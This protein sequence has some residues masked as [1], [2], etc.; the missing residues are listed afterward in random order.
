MTLLEC[1]CGVGN[2]VFPVSKLNPEMFIYCFDFS[3][4]AIRLVKE[5]KEY[6]QKKMKA[7]VCDMTKEEIKDV[8]DDSL[9]FITLIFVL[10]ALSPEKMKESIDKLYKVSFFLLYFSEIKKRRNHFC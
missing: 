7:F 4:E 3:H 1:G 8:P 10:S 6:D 5:N 9:D 2:T